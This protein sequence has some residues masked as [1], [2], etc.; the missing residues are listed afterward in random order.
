MSVLP[1]PVTSAPIAISGSGKT[2]TPKS[3]WNVPS[4]LLRATRTVSS[5]D[6]Q[7]PLGPLRLLGTRTSW[8]PSL[9][10]SAVVALPVPQGWMGMSLLGPNVPSPLLSAKVNGYGGASGAQTRSGALSPLRSEAKTE[11]TY[12]MMPAW[13]I[14]HAGISPAS[15]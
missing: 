10:A 14:E 2:V 1:S 11:R 13:Q 3:G 5:T 15:T 8:S 4:P 9:S 6:S 12:G 7:N